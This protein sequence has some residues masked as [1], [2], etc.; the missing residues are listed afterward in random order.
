M[1][2]H[3]FTVTSLGFLTGVVGYFVHPTIFIGI[4]FAVVIFI[5]TFFLKLKNKWLC[6][7]LFCVFILSGFIWSTHYDRIHASKIP[8]ELFDTRITV[9]GMVI[10]D[11]N[12]GINQTRIVVHDD[13]LGNVLVTLGTGAMINYG[14][15]VTLSGK[16]EQPG[17]FI[18][19]TDREFDYGNYLALHDVYGTMRA[20][21]FKIIAHDHGNWFVEKLF[22]VKNIFVSEIT[23]IFPSPE[24]GLFAGIIIGEKSLLPKN[25]LNDFQIAGLTHM[26]VLSGY[27][28]TIVAVAMIAILAWVGLGYRARRVGAII[29]I[30]IFLIMTGLGASSVRAGIM[31]MIVFIL[32][33]TTRPSQPF[34]IILLSLCA[35]VF[36][37][38]RTLLYDPSLHLS[39]L[40]FIGLVYMTPVIEKIFAKLQILLRTR[41]RQG[42]VKTKGLLTELVMQTIA[43]QVFVLP[44]ILYMNGRVSLLLFFANILTVPTVPII[45][46]TGFVVTIIGIIW[47]PLAMI[48]A[49]PIK[50]ALAYIIWIAHIVAAINVTTFTIPPFGVWWVIGVYFVI[51]IYLIRHHNYHY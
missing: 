28:I 24:S 18:T 31:A 12:R 51:M 10:D 34:R 23:R 42:T 26:I 45:M 32:Q 43:V 46:G 7:L 48:I 17:I 9:I 13:E 49:Y 21:D 38:P 35:M 29:I 39:F 27:N 47:N 5:T 1:K 4:I 20:Y 6:L 16:L 50:L 2:S 30:P 37:N 22:A 44:Y 11:P 25:N 14:D 41:L 8:N 3:I 36:F 33:I 15:M 40:A 19:D